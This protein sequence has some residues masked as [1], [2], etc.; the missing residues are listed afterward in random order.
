MQLD[1][2]DRAVELMRRAGT[3]TGLRTTVNVIRRAYETKRIATEQTKQP[4]R[5]DYDEFRSK[6]NYSLRH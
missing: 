4:L 5:I 3:L 1:T 2:I 6:W